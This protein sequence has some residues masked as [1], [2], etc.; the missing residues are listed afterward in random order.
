MHVLLEAAMSTPTGRHRKPRRAPKTK[1][2]KDKT[3]RAPNAKT[4]GMMFSIAELIVMVLLGT[5]GVLLV[6]M[7]RPLTHKGS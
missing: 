3:S 7:F 6:L 4:G 5:L 1:V 2:I